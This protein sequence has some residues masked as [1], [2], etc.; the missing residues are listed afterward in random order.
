MLVSCPGPRVSFSEISL[1]FSE[2]QMELKM[3]HS[4]KMCLTDCL[5]RHVS[6]KGSVSLLI[7]YECVFLVWPMRILVIKTSLCLLSLVQESGHFC[8]GF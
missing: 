1:M 8:V 5:H 6:H 4:V 2:V 7:W 3:G